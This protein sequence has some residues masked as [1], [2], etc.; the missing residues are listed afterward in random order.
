MQRDEVGQHRSG[1]VVRTA[2]NGLAEE[3]FKVFE[4]V[5]L[6][7]TK[8]SGQS[9]SF[10]VASRIARQSNRDTGDNQDKFLD[11][12]VNIS[13]AAWGGVVR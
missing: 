6:R 5:V 1:M 8:G 13:F 10:D 9:I 4:Q 2:L 12:A 11:V 7:I 3:T